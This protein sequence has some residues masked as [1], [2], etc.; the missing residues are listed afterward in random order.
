LDNFIHCEDRQQ[1]SKGNSHRLRAAGK[2]PG[3]V[4]GLNSSNMNVE[5]G[6][7]E[8]LK[9][10]EVSG[11]HGIIEIQRNGTSEKVIV[12]DV[13]RDPVTRELIHIDLQRVDENKRITTMVPI[14][15]RGESSLRKKE[16]VVQK[17][18]D[19]VEVEGRPG[20]L[21]RF[22]HIDVSQMIPGNRITFN[23]LE[24]SSEIS[25]IGDMD[26]II[27]AVA[28]LRENYQ[29]IAET[30]EEHSAPLIEPDRFY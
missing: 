14:V 18:V 19:A 17:Q 13:Q 7:M 22:F 6:S 29:D 9:V 1:V 10:L 30:A 12:R 26:T 4:Y 24:I 23:D 20:S 3:V 11:E 25:I 28:R 27:G 21:P 5:F 16:A 15:L 8:V 2:I